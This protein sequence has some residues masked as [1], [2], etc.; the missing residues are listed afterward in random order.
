MV[1]EGPCIAQFA[2]HSTA[3]PVAQF[4]VFWVVIRLLHLFDYL[5][6][7]L[8]E[9][10]MS[11]VS[12]TATLKLKANINAAEKFIEDLVENKKKTKNASIY[13]Y[14]KQGDEYHLYERYNHSTNWL[15][16]L[17]DFSTVADE[18]FATFEIENPRAFGPISDELRD[19]LAGLGFA[20]FET[21]A[22]T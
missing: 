2:H 22:T 13:E 5:H 19:A 21:V 6:L 12:M 10:V 8:G 1:R 17:E 15:A 20:F 18:F 14:H 9:K 16:H 11:S 7:K 4:N 3:R